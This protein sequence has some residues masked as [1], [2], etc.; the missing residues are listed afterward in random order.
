MLDSFS[1]SSAVLLTVYYL[2][3]GGLI[4]AVMRYSAGK[5]TFE[6]LCVDASYQVIVDFAGSFVVGALAEMVVGF[7]REP[8]STLTTC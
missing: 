7:G 8:C 4:G 6:R 3:A 2:L 1:Q 5:M